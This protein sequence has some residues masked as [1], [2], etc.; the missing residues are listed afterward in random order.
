[1]ISVMW[2]FPLAVMDSLIRRRGALRG[3]RRLSHL[4]WITQQEYPQCRCTTTPF[5]QFRTV[6]WDSGLSFD[7]GVCRRGSGYASQRIRFISLPAPESEE[8][9]LYPP[10]QWTVQNRADPAVP[11]QPGDRGITHLPG[12]N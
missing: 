8:L 6:S 4:D 2:I 10:F 3:R 1:M 5:H 12:W 11:D 9:E 7:N